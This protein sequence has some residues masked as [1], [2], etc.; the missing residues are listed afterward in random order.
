ML[1]RVGDERVGWV[2]N[3]RAWFEAAI[4]QRLTDQDKVALAEFDLDAPATLPL[5]DL[6]KGGRMDFHE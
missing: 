6:T 3:S 1:V 4:E 5:P 2:G